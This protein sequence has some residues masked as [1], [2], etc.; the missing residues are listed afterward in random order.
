MYKKRLNPT[1]APLIIILIIMMGV[2]TVPTQATPTDSFEKVVQPLPLIE[3]LDEIST[4][5]Q[6]FFSYE[7]TLLEKINVDF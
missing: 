6:V 4:R 1:A 2:S 3:I 5:Y 7:A